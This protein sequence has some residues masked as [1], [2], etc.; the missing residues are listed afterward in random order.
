VTEVRNA[1]RCPRVFALGRTGLRKT[2]AFPVGASSLGATFHRI[3]ELFS[4]SLD[5]PPEVVRGLP[6]GAPREDVAAALGRW[7][8][9]HLVDALEEAPTLASMPGEVDDLAEALRELA[10]YL[11]AGVERGD[12][13]PAEALRSLVQHAE[14]TVDAVVDAPAGV[15]VRITGRVDAVHNRAKAEGGR[16]RGGALDVVEYKLTDEANQALDQAQVALYRRLL[17][18]ALDLEAEPV[19]LRFNPGL[20]ATRLSAS[21]SEAIVVRTIL[22][23]LGRMV[24]WAEQPVTAPATARRDLCAACPVRVDCAET[25]RDRLE[26][27]D[28]PPSGATRPRPGREGRLDLTPAVADTGSVSADLDGETEL[29]ELEKLVVAELRRMGVTVV[30]ESRT[31]G[32]ALLRIEVRVGRQR[33]TQLDRVAQDVEHRLAERDVRF[34]RDGA[35]RLFEAP[36]RRPRPVDLAV[37]FGRTASFLRGRPGRFVVGEAIDGRAVTGDLSDGSTSHLLIG[38]Q[39]GS[40]KSVLLRGLVSS[41]CHFHPP[42]AVRFTLVDPKRVTFGP[43]AA[44]IAAH[45]EGPVFHDAESILPELDGLVA[46]MNDRY[47]RFERANVEDIDSYNEASREHLARRIV[48]VDEFQ[49]LI[50]DKATREDFLG[51]VKRLGSKARAAGIHL[52]CATQRP[53]A[54]TVPGELKANLGGRI[55]LKVQAAVNSRIILDEAGAEKLLGCGDLLVNLGHGVV[56]AQ[57]P[58]A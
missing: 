20:I 37:L 52:I 16:P 12:V 55:A 48:V 32:P 7:L 39:T 38:G 10:R 24:G 35:K 33:L 4:R 17:R 44:A 45:L 29:A 9:D 2:V 58:M 19:I 31:A 34:T 23:L 25:Y 1:L 27:R 14:L 36:R 56:R 5:A 42:Q 13:A 6:R 41:L 57:A 3:A 18:D 21:A 40:G 47:E 49:D 54:R 53:D 50:A 22:P 15:P 11:A 51:A 8:L 46:D 43:L 28:Q 26:P 30:V